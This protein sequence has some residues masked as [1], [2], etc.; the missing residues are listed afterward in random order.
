MA[1]SPSASSIGMVGMSIQTTENE[2]FVST[3]KFY[4]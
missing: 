3:F 4:R 1:S 2:Y